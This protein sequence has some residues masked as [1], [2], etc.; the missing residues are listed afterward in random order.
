MPQY[1]ALVEDAVAFGKAQP[2]SDEEKLACAMDRVAVNFGKE[3]VKIVPGY[4]STE[5]DARLSFDANA[6]VERG[7]RIIKCHPTHDGF[8]KFLR[9]EASNRPLQVLRGQR[10]LPGSHLDQD[11]EHL[12]GDSGLQ[13][14]ASRGHKLQHDSPLFAS[15]GNSAPRAVKKILIL[16]VILTKHIIQCA[17]CA[18]N[19]LL[20][21]CW[22]R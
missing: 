3:I 15:P 16:N 21:G 8:R 7:R 5:V 13:G 22:M 12:R 18:S 4:V 2:G 10:R 20:A 14:A 19:C 11:R 6:T 1:K 9:T 17:E